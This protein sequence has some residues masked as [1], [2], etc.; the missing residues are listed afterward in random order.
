M[1]GLM[2]NEDEIGMRDEKS[3]GELNFALSTAVVLF[4]KTSIVV[5]GRNR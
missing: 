5:N 2:T 1:K 3:F 4:G